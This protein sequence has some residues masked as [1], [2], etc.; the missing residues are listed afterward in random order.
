[1]TD[2][3]ENAGHVPLL[4]D[5][6][7]AKNRRI[8]GGNK[9]DGIDADSLSIL[10]V[11]GT[12]PL[13]YIPP[14]G[15]RDLRGLVRTR[16]GIR[17]QQA[18]FKQRSAW[19]SQFLVLAQVLMKYRLLRSAVPRWMGRPNKTCVRHST[20]HLS[21]TSIRILKKSKLH[22]ASA[23]SAWS[24]SLFDDDDQPFHYFIKFRFGDGSGPVD[25]DARICSEQPIGA[26][27]AALV[28][29]A[30]GEIDVNQSNLILIGSRLAC[31][32]TEDYI[33]A[34]ESRNNQRR[35]SLRLADVR[36]REVEDYNIAF[37]KL[38]QASSSSGA[39]QPLASEDSATNVG[40]AVSVCA[41][42]RDRRYASNLSRSCSC[43][44]SNSR[45]IN[46]RL[47]MASSAPL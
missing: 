8:G 43:M 7:E 6:A 37:Y 45:V 18:G 22:P 2:A 14:L 12:L 32:L 39:S 1:M 4:T 42:F 35:P 25:D 5:P 19:F 40:I 23:N 44:K 28:Q 24:S 41:S 11:N 46:S 34:F 29:P 26:N 21:R 9:S 27:S 20:V 47:L 30:E 13:V 36:E 33:V 15:I 17:R 38:A 3:I 16:P 10:N 31:D